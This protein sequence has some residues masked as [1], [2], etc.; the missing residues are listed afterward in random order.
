[1][2]G[3]AG[4]V[5]ETYVDGGL[6]HALCNTEGSSD[7]A[8]MIIIIKSES[9]QLKLTVCWL[10]SVTWATNYKE[11]A[12][13]NLMA[14]HRLLVMDYNTIIKKKVTEPVEDQV[15]VVIVEMLF[16]GYI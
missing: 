10:D 2:N 11:I 15:M 13:E 6:G 1:M 5:A 4:K 9:T 14:Q 3:H 16:L 7:L 12:S 8:I